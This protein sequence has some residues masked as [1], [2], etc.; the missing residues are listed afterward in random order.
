MWWDEIAIA[1]NVTERGWGELLFTPLMHFQVAPLGFLFLEK[2]GVLL[3]G[4]T[5]IGFRLFPF[6]LSLGA[7]VLF[8]RVSARYLRFPTML[9]ALI[10]FALSP[11]LVFYAGT[12]KQYSGDI[13]A[14]LLLLWMTLRWLDHRPGTGEA[15][16]LGVAGGAAILLSHPAVLVAA[17]LGVT[18]LAG[19]WRRGRP[20]RRLLPMLAG[21]ALGAGMIT[22]ASLRTLSASTDQVMV[23]FWGA[24][25]VPPP[26]EGGRELFWVPV[27]LIE[28]LVFFVAFLYSPNSVPEIAF[29][30]VFG[31]LLVLGAIHLSR[32]DPGAALVL[33]IPVAVAVA[34]ASVRLLPL[35]ERVSLFLGPSL[36]IA[37]FAGFDRMRAWLPRRME[38]LGL[39]AALGFAALPGLALLIVS[40][41]PRK[42]SESRAV[43]QEVHARRLPEDELVVVRWWGWIS[44]EYYGHRLGLADWTLIAPLEGY[45]MDQVL[46]D[47]LDQ[48]DAFRGRSRVW[49]FLDR[50]WDC[51]EEAVLGY[52]GAIGR[53]RD[54][55]EARI[56]A[57]EKVSAHLYDL[58]DPALLARAS[59]EEYPVPAE[60]TE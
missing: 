17:G 51:E 58:S 57:D 32:T 40:P 24:G 28:V 13:A 14:C 27:R 37:S 1:L 8:W 22:Y 36:L 10:A 48:L 52:L 23:G 49:V 60:C 35:I 7:L 19:A 46:R 54:V 5:E 33:A 53:R 31:V 47:Y 34:A 45:P 38:R 21:W 50:T 6:L 20:L 42:R 30:A 41:P 3:L 18:L 12:V 16:L 25:F 26:W 2:L 4:D 59:A 11:T 39:L 29:A 55:V 44:T 9:A 15:A 56:S 43:L